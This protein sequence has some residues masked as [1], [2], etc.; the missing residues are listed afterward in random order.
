MC[1]LRF[2]H[3]V[4]VEAKEKLPQVGMTVALPSGER[5]TVTDLNIFAEKVTVLIRTEEDTRAVTLPASEV[6]PARACGDCGTGGSGCGGGCGSGTCGISPKG[7]VAAPPIV[8]EK[9]FGNGLPPTS[10]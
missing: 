9:R 8:L 5:G 7:E 1:C 6:R 10:R 3:D 4:Y 2:E